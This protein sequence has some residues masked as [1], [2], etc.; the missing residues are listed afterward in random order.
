[1]VSK[2]IKR[3]IKEA[4]KI[5]KFEELPDVLKRIS[6]RYT[7]GELK[8]IAEGGRIVPGQERVPIIDFEGERIKFGIISDTHLGSIFATEDWIYQAFEI[9]QKERCEFICHAGDVVEGM[10][11][12]KGHIY[13]LTHLG[14]DAQR[15]YAVKVFSQW[16]KKIYFIDG[17]HDRWFAKDVGALMVKDICSRLKN[18]EFL[19]H[20]EGDIS[21]KGKA[22]MKLWHG[23]DGSS[24]AIS[25]RLQ[26][27]IEA[28]V[29]GEKPGLLIAGHIHKSGY[30]FDRFVH[31][32]SAGALSRQSRWMRTK[33]MAHHSG[34]W[35]VDLKVG[36]KGIARI[37]LEWFPFYA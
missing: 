28:F 23:E 12:R 11:G 15:D 34:F 20:D 30:F 22:V 5:Q 32:V 36:K 10:S 37:K 8:A 29:G 31:V 33:R 19:G 9:F 16:K 14:Y 25:Y 13:E 18:A 26:K 27:I 3:K 1:M 4:K 6:E 21:L 7:I 24:Y 35:V 2:E 17:N